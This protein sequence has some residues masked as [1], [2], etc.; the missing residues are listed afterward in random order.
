VASEFTAAG[1]E[2]VSSWLWVA[3]VDVADDLE[4]GG[5]AARNLA[6][7]RRAEMLVAFTEA[8]HVEKAGR[9]GRHVELGAALVLGLAVVVVGPA[10][11]VFHQADGVIRFADWKSAREKLLVA[12]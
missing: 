10:E 5:A 2:V 4:A 12:T 8:A 1:T 6:D 3:G 7:L 11:H 9:G